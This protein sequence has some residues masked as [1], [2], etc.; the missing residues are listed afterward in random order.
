MG[1]NPGAEHR[2]PSLGAT[3]DADLR[4]MK[5][6]LRDSG[7][8]VQKLH[9][10]TR[11]EITERITRLS[12]SMSAGSTLLIYFTGHGVRIGDT[13]YLVPADARAPA[14]DDSDDNDPTTW[15]RPHVRESLLDSDISRYLADC[16][17]GT[18]LW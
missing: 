15:T 5:A 8:T 18:V 14:G 12:E 2:L 7:Y 13:D 4:V 6:A 9:N 1:A 11:N 10:P 16:S 3:V 17:A